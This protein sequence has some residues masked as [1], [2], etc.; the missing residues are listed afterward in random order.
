ML[1]IVGGAAPTVSKETEL[2]PPPE[3]ELLVSFKSIQQT[4][5][6]DSVTAS[7]ESI[8]RGTS[9]WWNMA[10]GE[11][12]VEDELGHKFD[13]IEA[14]VLASMLSTPESRERIL[15]VDVRGRDWVGGH[16]PSSINL[17]T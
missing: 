6:R 1:A 4:P 9:G 13:L 11:Q 12:R 15:T 3:N 17:R 5:P 14:H 2:E 7:I 8:S 16:I 10:V